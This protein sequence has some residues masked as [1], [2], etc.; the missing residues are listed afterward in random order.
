M[1]MINVMSFSVKYV[2][3]SLYLNDFWKGLI[4]LV[5]MRLGGFVGVRG[6]F[7]F[8]MRLENCLEMLVVKLLKGVILI[9]DEIFEMRY[10]ER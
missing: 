9:G 6:M 8:L 3:L 1:N 5:W 4:V 10:G 7:I 2:Y